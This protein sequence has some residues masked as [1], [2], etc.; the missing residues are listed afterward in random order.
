MNKP[1]DIPDP[2]AEQLG[3]ALKALTFRLP[4]EVH[5]RVLEF[6]ERTGSDGE[7]VIQE[8]LQERVARIESVAAAQ[9]RVDR[10]TLFLPM[11]LVNR[12]RDVCDF[13]KLNQDEVIQSAVRDR[14]A[15]VR[16]KGAG[17]SRG[18]RRPEKEPAEKEPVAPEPKGWADFFNEA[19]P[20]STP[21]EAV[22]DPST[23]E[24]MR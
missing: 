14:V 2:E 9:R 21:G 6:C 12:L 11:D 3:P 7:A 16:G 5:K 13:Y 24:P 23:P 1:A 8:A 19:S 20:A 4:F 10:W 17:G 18:R 22:S 15:R